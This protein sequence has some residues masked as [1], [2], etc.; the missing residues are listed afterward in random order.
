MYFVQSTFRGLHHGN[1]V[2]SV[3]GSLSQTTDLPAH[4]L[5]DCEACRVI[6]SL[7]DPVAGRQPRDCFAVLFIID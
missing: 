3:G 7:I 4:F 1:T 5:G 2:L 6:S